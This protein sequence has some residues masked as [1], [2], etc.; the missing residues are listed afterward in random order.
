MVT[1]EVTNSAILVRQQV[2]GEEETADPITALQ[3]QQIKSHK[4]YEHIANHTAMWDGMEVRRS[5][6]FAALHE[7]E[8]DT[9]RLLN[10]EKIDPKL[11]QAGQDKRLEILKQR[12]KNP[13]A[14]VQERS[15]AEVLWVIQ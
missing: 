6:I 7:L 5:N 1:G 10:A 4:A 15:V 2:E 12:Q 11:A 9:Q 13:R 8:K 3:R 14:Q